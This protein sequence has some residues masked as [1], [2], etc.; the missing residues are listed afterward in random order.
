MAAAAD[1]GGVPDDTIVQLQTA[2][3]SLFELERRHCRNMKTIDHL[4]EDIDFDL[5]DGGGKIGPIPVPCPKEIMPII[6]SYCQEFGPNP[7]QRPIP[8]K[9]NEFYFVSKDEETMKGLSDAPDAHPSKFDLMISTNYLDFQPALWASLKAIAAGLPGKNVEQLKIHFGVS[10]EPF[11]DE[12]K[13]RAKEMFPYLL[14]ED[15]TAI[16]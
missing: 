6:I 4:L 5:G 2:D 11:T 1:D 13:A 10:S 9:S 14:D 3:G 12:E 16:S 7:D 15:L 8:T